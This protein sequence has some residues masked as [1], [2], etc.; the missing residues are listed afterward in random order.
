M[1]RAF[2]LGHIKAKVKEMDS[3]AK[4]NKWMDKH[5]DPVGEKFAWLLPRMFKFAESIEHEIYIQDPSRICPCPMRGKVLGLCRIDP[6]D[7][8]G[9]IYLHPE[10]SPDERCRVLMHECTHGLG[11]NKGDDGT[12]EIIAECTAH[13]VCREFGLDTWNFTYP[14]L[15]YNYHVECGNFDENAINMYAKEILAAL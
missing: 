11:A 14:Y 10:L 4:C 3:Q 6:W 8:K 15:A 13:V 5:P 1:S 2:D 9:K 7:G 12:M